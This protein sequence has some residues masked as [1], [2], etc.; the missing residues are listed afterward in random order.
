MKSGTTIRAQ[1]TCLCTPWA[2]KDESGVWRN[3]GADEGRGRCRRTFAYFRP[4][5]IARR[6]ISSH[7]TK[8]SSGRGHGTWSN[9]M[10]SLSEHLLEN[11]LG[12]L[13]LPS[14]FVL[15]TACKQWN[16]FIHS[17]SF[18]A[19]CVRVPPPKQAWFLLHGDGKECVAFNPDVQ[20]MAG[21][22]S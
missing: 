22:P 14:Y 19:I 8:A 13:P 3:S 12:L 1:I 21:A 20:S 4:Y 10:R 18:L 2:S 11:I 16:A 15:R 5:T 7:N 6:S 17:P 9:D